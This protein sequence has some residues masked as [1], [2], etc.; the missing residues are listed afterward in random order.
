ADNQSK[1]DP[2]HTHTAPPFKLK[3]CNMRATLDATPKSH[4]T[5]LSLPPVRIH[6]TGSGH[7]GSRIVIVGMAVATNI[8]SILRTGALRD[9]SSKG[10]EVNQKRVKNKKD[11]GLQREPQIRHDLPE[12]VEEGPKTLEGAVRTYEPDPATTWPTSREYAWPD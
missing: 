11:D 5:F 6:H 7:P 10:S 4:E 2:W 1:K 9:L 3:N 12:P 8:G